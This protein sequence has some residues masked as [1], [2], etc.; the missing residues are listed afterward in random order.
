MI[1]R[2]DHDISLRSSRCFGS[3]HRPVPVGF[4]DGLSSLRWRWDCWSNRAHSRIDPLRLQVERAST[5]RLYGAISEVNFYPSYSH[6]VR[7]PQEIID[8]LSTQG[9]SALYRSPGPVID[10]GITVG[11]LAEVG[12]AAIRKNHVLNSFR[13]WWA[14]LSYLDGHLAQISIPRSLITLGLIASTGILLLAVSVRPPKASG[15][16]SV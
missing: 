14:S 5:F 8:V 13:P 1:P 10:V 15:E 3:S 9:Q 6:L 11:P 16:V 2:G 12:P 4:A 7:R